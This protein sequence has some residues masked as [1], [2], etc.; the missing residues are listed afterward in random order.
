[1]S[2]TPL[3]TAAACLQRC[4]L[5]I[6]NDGGQMHLSAAAG[7]PTLG[8]FGPTPA[9]HYRPWGKLSDYVQAP[10]PFEGLEARIPEAMNAG[11]TLM[12]GIGVDA[13][14][15]A[16]RRLLLKA[17]PSRSS[18]PSCSPHIGERAPA[19]LGSGMDIG[20]KPGTM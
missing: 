12:G 10:E 16:A 18:H 9:H 15:A 3:L 11:I 4:A 6:G 8:L 19:V 2:N 14:E 7:V 5:Y 13:V 1:M 20:G 17:A